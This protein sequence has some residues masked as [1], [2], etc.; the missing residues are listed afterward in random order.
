MD[1][2]TNAE[3]FI[4]AFTKIEKKLNEVTRRP[5]Y[6]PFRTNAR[7]ASRYNTVIESN[8][9]DLNTFAELR[10]CLVHFRDGKEEVIAEPTEEI[11]AAIEGRDYVIPEDVKNNAVEVLAHRL[12]MTA[13]SHLSPENYIRQLLDEIPVPVE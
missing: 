3:R 7:I 10:N 2:Q 9:E 1:T 8:L 11:T 4:V 5:K 12:T 6:I 13:G